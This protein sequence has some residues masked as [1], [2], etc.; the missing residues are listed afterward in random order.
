MSGSSDSPTEQGEKAATPK[1]HDVEDLAAEQLD[2]VRKTAENWR[3]GLAG[4]LALVATVLFL[5]GP[6]SISKIVPWARWSVSIMLVLC[7]SLALAGA[8][9][10]LKAAFGTPRSVDVAEIEYEGGVKPYRAGLARKAVGHLN[11]AKRLTVSA[12]VMLSAATLLYWNAPVLPGA[13]FYLRVGLVATSSQP[14]PQPICGSPLLIK[15]KHIYIQEIRGTLREVE[16][17]SIAA[18]SIVADC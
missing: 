9:L 18:L 4:L 6:E 14:T 16:M 17:N 15:D 8:W 10:S 11:W 7:L 3:T 5:K 1:P 12:V 2:T 13:N